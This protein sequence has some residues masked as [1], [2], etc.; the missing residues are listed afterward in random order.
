MG[1]FSVSLICFK[2]RFRMQV[3]KPV[4]GLVMNLSAWQSSRSLGPKGCEWN[5]LEDGP[6]Q[7]SRA[8]RTVTGSARKYLSTRKFCLC[9]PEGRG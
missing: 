8:P 4:T 7:K 2:L 1:G 3:Q 9:Y 5:F 6:R